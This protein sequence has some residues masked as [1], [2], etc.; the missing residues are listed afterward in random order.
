MRAKI[1]QPAKNA[2]QSGRGNEKRWVLDY[3][4]S[5]ARKIDPL[6]G[7]T[8]SG[9]MGSQIRMTFDTRSEQGIEHWRR[10]SVALAK[11]VVEFGGSLSGEHGDG[12]A[13]AEFLPIMWGSFST[14]PLLS[15]S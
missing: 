9:D 1:Y 10:F 12:Q 13:K 14:I 11:L 4:A 7:W 3:V 5:K 8:S 6:M 2:M 15:I